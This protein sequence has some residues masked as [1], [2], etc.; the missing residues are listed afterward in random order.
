MPQN[1]VEIIVTTDASGAVTGIK[2]LSGEVTTFT[3]K[4]AEE[5]QTLSQRIKGS[6]L[7]ISAA[8]F[9]A[10]ASIKKGFDLMELGAKAQQAEEA[11][12]NVSKSY[13]ENADQLIAN[14][15]RASNATVDESNI[16][17]K[18]IKGMTQ[19]ISGKDMTRLLEVARIEARR[20]GQ[21]VGQTF[22]ELVD[23]IANNMP[24]ALKRFGLITK[25]EMKNFETAVAE[26][27][28]EL[29]LL[30]IVLARGTLHIAQLGGAAEDSAEKMQQIKASLQDIKESI[31]IFLTNVLGKF[32]MGWEIVGA[33]AGS[34]MLKI[35]AAIKL[36]FAEFKNIDA[37]Y[38]K[39]V[40]DIQKKWG[41]GNKEASPVGDVSGA[42][43][44]ID[45]IDKKLKAI[46][47]QGKA[48]EM[49]NAMLEWQNKTAGLNSELDE[50]EKKLL[51]LY[52]EAEKLKQK[53]KQEKWGA[54]FIAKI[55]EGLLKGSMEIYAEADKEKEKKRFEEY[56]KEQAETTEKTKEFEKSI[57]EAKA[58]EVER[59]FL[60]VDEWAKKE[61][62]MLLALWGK[63]ITD[64]A[65]F[66]NKKGEITQIAAD[67][68]KKIEDE[69]NKAIREATI[70]NQ[71][72]LIDI[73]E[74][75]RT[76]SKP[77]AIKQRISL[78]QELVGI[79]EAHLATLDK[80]KDPS[81]WYAQQKEITVTK[82]K[83][84]ELNLAMKEQTGT[85]QEG[86]G[87][88]FRKYLTELKTT[89]QQGVEI[90]RQT[91]QAMEGAF[92]D[93]FFDAFQGKLKSLADYLKSFL[94]SFQ[95]AG[96][97]ALGQQVTGSIISSIAGYARS[98]GASP[99]APATTVRHSGGLIMHEGGYVPRFHFGGLSSDEV[100]A[101]LQRGEYVVSREGVAA[102]D[103]INQGKVLSSD[104]GGKQEVHN[105]YY[106]QAVDAKSFA[107]LV[108]RN[109][110]AIT[111]IMQDDARRGGSLWR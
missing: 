109:P 66:E 42:K 97:Q 98:A 70:N 100:P 17:Q 99:R 10:Y 95:R 51:E 18:A 55:D 37:D 54:G 58:K 36:N 94:T 57:T 92:S 108:E 7:E 43:K 52:N 15:K 35:K 34:A 74:K 13:G 72:S 40:A 3:K 73:T 5:H 46:A 53:A 20:A 111:K 48:N 64:Y 71:L 22:D 9:A 75:E 32:A 26:G 105:Y 25:E 16:M 82:D 102:M 39:T 93:F 86:F 63:S 76:I 106:I 50:T 84:L 24:R 44:D 96:A 79:Q 110:G 41:Q 61:N 45:D 1:K 83:L 81:S 31:G 89:F 59:R 38:A 88:G 62:D 60:E 30:N 65:E 56:M 6:W 91:A 2:T 78:N 80:L 23:S 28:T 12:R 68:R 67:K 101:I 21:D 11:F 69:T 107:D 4:A 85:F 29:N 14:L 27:H 104:S 19:D 77:E 103:A 49:A 8:A 33:T 90:A 87:Q 47:G